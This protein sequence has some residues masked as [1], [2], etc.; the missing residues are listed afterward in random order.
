VCIA[1]AT[2]DVITT[3]ECLYPS[4]GYGEVAVMITTVIREAGRCEALLAADDDAGDNQGPG[5]CNMAVLEA[6]TRPCCQVQGGM[7]RWHL[8]RH[9]KLDQRNFCGVTV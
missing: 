9:S 4:G 7:R 1:E 3:F 5:L 6:V 2:G 8:Q